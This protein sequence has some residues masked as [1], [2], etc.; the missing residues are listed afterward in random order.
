[1][2]NLGEDQR[3]VVFEPIDVPEPIVEPVPA[4]V[5]PEKVPVGA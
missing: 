1:M 4:P 5:E 2:G 3:E